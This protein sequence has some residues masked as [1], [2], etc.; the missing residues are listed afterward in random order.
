MI[1]LIQIIITAVCSAGFAA[2]LTAIFSYKNTNRSQDV[3]DF[4]TL[5]NE[6]K[7]LYNKS[8]T[9]IIEL[10]KDN[11]KLH[12]EMDNY[13]MKMGDL[14]HKIVL[15]EASQNELPIAYWIKDTNLR[16]LSFNKEFENIF[17]KPFGKQASDYRQYTDVEFWGEEIAKVFSKTDNY[18]IDNGTKIYFIEPF[19]KGDGIQKYLYCVK[20]PRYLGKSLVG[21]AGLVL[22]IYNDE[23]DLKHLH[24]T[25]NEK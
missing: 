11:K 6:Y 16:M 13:K 8:E 4:S 24:I 3:T 17:I 22:G 21:V 15:L 12:F 25:Y 5:V 10:E 19:I 14:I 7:D 23:N 18:V 9:R 1:P 20:Y 2:V